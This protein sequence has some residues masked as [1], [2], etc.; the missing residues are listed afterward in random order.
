MTYP[1]ISLVQPLLNLCT[2]LHASQSKAA[3]KLPLHLLER[4]AAHDFTD[5][6][7]V[8]APGRVELAGN[9]TDHQGGRVISAALNQRIYAFVAKNNSP[10][11]NLYMDGFT[12]EHIDISDASS[13]A[14]DS[15]AF[16]TSRSIVLGMI[17]SFVKQGG[18]VEGFDLVSCSTLPSG[19][20]LSS[21]AAFEMLI[22]MSLEVLFGNTCECSGVLHPQSPLCLALSGMQ[23]EREFFGKP[24]GAQDQITSAF[25]GI[26]AMDFKN[27]LPEVEKIR[28]DFDTTSYALCLIDS[29]CDHSAHTNDFTQLTSDMKNVAACFGKER[30]EEVG[31]EAFLARF[32]DTRTQLGD[33]PAMRALHYFAETKRVERQKT[34]LQNQDFEAFLKDVLASGASSAQF[35]Q[36]VS[37]QS[38]TQQP[39]MVILALCAQLLGEQGAWRVHGGGF[40]GSA[41]A[42]VPAGKLENFCN[43]MDEFLGYKA[44]MPVRISKYGTHALPLG[45]LMS[46]EA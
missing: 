3:D 44:C 38:D 21:S 1:Y 24:C 26:V 20:G 15:N 42:F 16:G 25:G 12:E 7:F 45:S 35:L 23:V 9:H 5:I 36:N 11:V 8:S 29:K 17:A 40:G 41:L 34:A 27:E 46:K 30:L 31:E 18:C 10:Y 28:F 37:P 39:V 6:F 32:S 33:L 43:T 19:G 22:G 14:P 4:V 2:E 13:F